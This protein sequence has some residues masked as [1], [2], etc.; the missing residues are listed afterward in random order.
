MNL[1]C[2]STAMKSA[3]KLAKDT[4]F[5]KY[6]SNSI[7]RRNKK[8]FF[9][10]YGQRNNTTKAINRNRLSAHNRPEFNQPTIDCHSLGN[11][12]ISTFASLENTQTTENYNVIENSVHNMNEYDEAREFLMD[13]WNKPNKTGD[14]FI[15]KSRLETII[16][17]CV[18]TNNDIH[19]S[20]PLTNCS[21][22]LSTFKTINDLSSL[23]STSAL[24]EKS[25]DEIPNNSDSRS[26]I[27]DSWGHFDAFESSSKMEYDPNK[28][29][30]LVGGMTCN[31]Y[32]R[33]HVA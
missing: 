17:E 23:I 33:A 32:R 26:E 15:P 28:Y 18:T 14:V 21:R 29:F 16:E 10:S 2:K 7:S 27:I 31:K 24:E 3:N 11:T 22:K 8:N 19:S 6:Q 1:I 20:L 9:E 13:L 5:S 4:A 12:T 30:G 25:F